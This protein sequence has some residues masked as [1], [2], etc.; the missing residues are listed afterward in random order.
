MV[1]SQWLDVELFP[2]LEGG[3][4]EEEEEEAAGA[5]PAGVLVAPGVGVAGARQGAREAAV[6]EEQV[7]QVGPCRP[8]HRRRQVTNL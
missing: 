4:L 6:S 7:A 2:Q 5:A 3:D 1:A 8:E